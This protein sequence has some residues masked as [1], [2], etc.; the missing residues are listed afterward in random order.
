M[1]WHLSIQSNRQLCQSVG[2]L[3]HISLVGTLFQWPESQESCSSSSPCASFLDSPSSCTAPFFA[4][5]V[6][7]WVYSH[8]R[9]SCFLR[10][11]KSR[12]LHSRK[13]AVSLVTGINMQDESRRMEYY[14]YSMGR[15]LID[16]GSSIARYS[17]LCSVNFQDGGQV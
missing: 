1:C 17:A 2:Y 13:R 12:S 3:F 8:Q 4:M 11:R 15:S 7:K 10:R 5:P 9:R 6:W 16:S 14:P